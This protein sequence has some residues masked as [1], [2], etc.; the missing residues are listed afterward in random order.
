MLLLLYN[1]RYSTI[2]IW[3]YERITEK[4][5]WI[6]IIKR[7][8]ITIKKNDHDQKLEIERYKRTYENPKDEEGD[9]GGRNYYCSGFLT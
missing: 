5:K 1:I 4:N 9:C 2:D 8:R 6:K 3:I 7:T